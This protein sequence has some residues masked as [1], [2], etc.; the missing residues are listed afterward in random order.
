MASDQLQ[1]KYQ[2]FQLFQQQIEQ[3]SQHLELLHQQQGE[4]ENSIE[5]LQVLEKTPKNREL[6]API[7]DGIFF[8]AELK[9]TQKL[10]VNVGS[11]VAVEKTIP[12]VVELLEQQQQD[13]T[14]RLVEA[15]SILQQFTAQ[16]KKLY[17]ELQKHV[18]QTEGQA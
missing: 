10:V 17:Q 12:Q 8:Q 6:L 9:D 2:Q 4:L 13:I 14:E 11:N 5:A 18:Q 15:E 7:A 3:I 16:A 1:Q